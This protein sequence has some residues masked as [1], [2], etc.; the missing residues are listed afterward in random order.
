LVCT[1]LHTK[2]T[3]DRNGDSNP[4]STFRKNARIL[5]KFAYIVALTQFPQECD[6]HDLGT[7]IQ[8]ELSLDEIGRPKPPVA[9][10]EAM[11]ELE[12]L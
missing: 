5:Q 8:A 4:L 9:P 1:I 3:G 7:I 2:S 6:F 11:A 12:F 10:D